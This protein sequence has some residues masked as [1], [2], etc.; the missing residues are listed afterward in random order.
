MNSETDTRFENAASGVIRG[1][2]T[3]ITPSVGLTNRGVINPGH[4]IGGLTIDGDLHQ[5]ASGV[6]DIE[7][8]SLSRFDRLTV[9]DDVT[10][11]GTLAI[12]NDGYIPAIGDRFVVATFDER[13]A[14]STFSSVIL[15]GFGPGTDFDV[16]YNPHD[17]T[18]AVTAIPQAIVAS[19]AAA[20]TAAP[21]PRVG[22][23]ACGFGTGRPRGA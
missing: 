3:V 22:D 13:L 11:G 4:L 21:E 19:S 1:P 23:A 8:A 6:L 16:I 20:V 17:V 18:L 7:L 9:T 14:G 15:N 12:T 10:F 2:G 5:A